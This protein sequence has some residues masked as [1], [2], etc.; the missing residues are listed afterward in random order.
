MKAVKTVCTQ[1][2]LYQRKKK[3]ISRRGLVYNIQH[4]DGKS[5]MALMV[6]IG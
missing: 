2:V 1:T 5:T 3:P 6:S 4:V